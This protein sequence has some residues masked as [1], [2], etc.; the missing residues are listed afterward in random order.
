MKINLKDY[1][2]NYLNITCRWA[3]SFRN[4]FMV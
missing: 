3:Q 4:V 1:M 2:K